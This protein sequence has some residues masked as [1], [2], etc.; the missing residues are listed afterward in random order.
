M[1]SDVGEE[2]ANLILEQNQQGDGTDADDT[3]QQRPQ[4]AH[5]QNLGD[6]QPEDDEEEH[7][8]EDV[9][10]ARFLHQAVGIVQENGYQQ[11]VYEVFEAEGEEHGGIYYFTIYNLQFTIHYRVTIYCRGLCH[12][13]IVNGPIVQ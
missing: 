4:Q 6:E 5:L 12:C 11:D 9:Q 3:I 8:K 2:L 7:T 10:R 1:G 13:P